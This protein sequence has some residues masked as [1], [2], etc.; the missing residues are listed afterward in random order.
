MRLSRLCGFAVPVA[1]GLMVVFAGCASAGHPR[2]EGGAVALTVEGV[3]GSAG[4]SASASMDK[5]L[6]KLSA[7]LKA[8]GL[9]PKIVA[10]GEPAPEGLPSVVVRVLELPRLGEGWRE[11]RAVVSARCVS[12]GRLV[13]EHTYEEEVFSNWSAQGAPTG[14]QP[15]TRAMELVARAIAKDVARALAE[16]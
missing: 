9:E 4:P 1:V 15:Q 11:G 8:R 10:E 2:A 7:G 13:L 6:G 16:R 5:F 14:D 12:Q 3:G